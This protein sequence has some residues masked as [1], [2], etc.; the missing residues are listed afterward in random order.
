MT[1]RDKREAIDAIFMGVG[2]PMAVIGG[3]YSLFDYARLSSEQL[4]WKT[5]IEIMAPELTATGV[6]IFLTVL[7]VI[8]FF[9]SSNRQAV[10]NT[11]KLFGKLWG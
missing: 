3:L 1:A 11:K 9:A 10:Q 6:E 4:A 7:S 8:I 5:I 2:L